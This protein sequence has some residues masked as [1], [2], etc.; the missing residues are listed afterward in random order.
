MVSLPHHFYYAR[1]L[2]SIKR[3][4]SVVSYCLPPA[5]F[6]EYLMTTT[7]ANP[8]ISPCQWLLPL[9]HYYREKT[10]HCKPDYN[11]QLAGSI[12]SGDRFEE[13]TL[14]KLKNDSCIYFAS[15]IFSNSLYRLAS[16]INR[17]ANWISICMS[18]AREE[19]QSP[20]T[21]TTSN[22]LRKNIR[23]KRSKK[24]PP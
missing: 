13:I 4:H 11:F 15:N 14:V 8:E 9:F 16:Q 17:T 23:T 12:K 7:R 21:S 5:C 24:T 3:H 1:W 18:Q 19:L 2:D 6:L 22:R 20:Y 10:E